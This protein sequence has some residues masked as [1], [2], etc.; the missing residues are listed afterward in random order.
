MCNGSGESSSPPALVLCQ[1]I[2]NLARR[3]ATPPPAPKAAVCVHGLRP[4]V[5]IAALDA[6]PARCPALWSPGRAC[7]RCR[8]PH[9]EIGPVLA[10]DA[11]VDVEDLE[12]PGGR[13]WPRRRRA[14]AVVELEGSDASQVLS[15]TQTLMCDFLVRSHG[16]PVY[17]VRMSPVRADRMVAVEDRLSRSVFS[18]RS[19]PRC[20]ARPGSCSS[21]M[22]SRRR[23]SS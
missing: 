14:V 16:L 12:A 9:Q 5:Q 18:K 13:S 8:Q 19:P 20:A 11:P 4:F 6:C 1:D 23:R 2:P 10:H 17:Q 21:V 7:R 15:K 22:I 3:F